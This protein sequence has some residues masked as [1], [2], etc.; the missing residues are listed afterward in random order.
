M[1]EKLNSRKSAPLQH[2]LNSFLTIFFSIYILPCNFKLIFL[3][4][5]WNHLISSE[6]TFFDVKK[7]QISHAVSIHCVTHTSSP[8]YINILTIYQNNLGMLIAYNNNTN[9]PNTSKQ[10]RT[11]NKPTADE[12]ATPDKPQAKKRFQNIRNGLTKS[13]RKLL[14]PDLASL[15]AAEPQAES[16]THKTNHLQLIVSKCRCEFY[17]IDFEDKIG[18]DE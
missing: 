9:V 3:I 2:K 17:M 6:I 1:L 7:L 11:N 15:S 5:A 18:D 8:I 12:G 13:N 16:T 4:S 14:K 10:P